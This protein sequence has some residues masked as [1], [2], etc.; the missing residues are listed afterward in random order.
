M[1]E[2]FGGLLISIIRRA[3]PLEGGVESV[4]GLVD[5]LLCPE[6]ENLVVDSGI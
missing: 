6:G 5:L 3:G 4:V 1:I 2:M